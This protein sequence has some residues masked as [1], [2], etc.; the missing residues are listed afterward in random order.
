MQLYYFNACGPRRAQEQD[1][2]VREGAEGI[3]G[4]EGVEGVEGEEG[5]ERDTTYMKIAA[6]YREVWDGVARLLAKS[7]EIDKYDVLGTA[8]L[9]IFWL[10]RLVIL[11][12]VIGV[13][14]MLMMD[15]AQRRF[16]SMEEGKSVLEY[17]LVEKYR[18]WAVA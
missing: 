8:L 3:E 17:V 4:V 2:Q 13:L 11:A 16:G 6:K 15:L 1:V 10:H 12:A 9:A 14:T 18:S 5:G 7:K